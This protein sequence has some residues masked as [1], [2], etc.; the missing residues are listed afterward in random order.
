MS[1]TDAITAEILTALKWLGAT[2]SL[3]ARLKHADKDRLYDAAEKLGAD[4]S[5][6]GYIGSWRDT[7]TDADVLDMLRA[8]NEGEQAD[9]LEAVRRGYGAM[10]PPAE[11]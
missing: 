5:L 1:D 2:P 8:W 10:K 4:R 7:M 3:L 11:S 9:A 6:L